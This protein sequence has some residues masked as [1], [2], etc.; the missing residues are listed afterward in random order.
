[1]TSTLLKQ[2]QVGYQH[3]LGLQKLHLK[4][5]DEFI[6]YF[7][8]FQQQIN[9]KTCNFHRFSGVI[10]KAQNMLIT[11]FLVRLFP[12]RVFLPTFFLQ[13]STNF[14]QL[15]SLLANLCT[16]FTNFY[17]LIPPSTNFNY[18]LSILTNFYDTSNFYYLSPT[19]TNF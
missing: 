5:I 14:Y 17:K 1:M 18:L 19:F 8:T 12:L 9:N 15:L 2:M 4:K 10:F 11:P 16:T 7:M 6:D 13:P 3:I